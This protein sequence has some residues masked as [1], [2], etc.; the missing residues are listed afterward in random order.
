[1]RKTGK[2]RMVLLVF[3]AILL[4]VTGVQT[5]PA[6]ESQE[7]AVEQE[8]VVDSVS[9][10]KYDIEVL[11]SDETKGA[12]TGE[13]TYGPEEEVSIQAIPSEGYQFKQ[14]IDSNEEIVST[15]AQYTFVPT[16]SQS[17]YAVFEEV[18]KEEISD[19]TTAGIAEET[20]MGTHEE[21]DLISGEPESKA[22]AR[23]I[24]SEINTDKI[25]KTFQST[26]K[27][28]NIKNL[29]ASEH[30][31]GY[32]LFKWSKES[33]FTPSG[34]EVHYRTKKIG[35]SSWSG[36]TTKSFGAN[37]YAYKCPVKA[38]YVVE[39]HARAKGDTSWSQGVITTPA[40]GT[41]QA[42]KTVYVTRLDTN[43]HVGSSITIGLGE[44]I[45]VK[46][47]YEYP[48]RDYTKR[49]RLYPNHMLYDVANTSVV[50]VVK[51]DGT[52]YT[53]GI[54]DGLALIRGKKAGKTTIVFRAPNGRTQV[55][56]VTVSAK[57]A[58]PVS[59]VKYAENTVPTS[60]ADAKVYTFNDS[61]TGTDADGNSCRLQDVLATNENKK[62]VLKGTIQFSERYRVGSNTQIEATGAT[63]YSGSNGDGCLTNTV[64]GVNYNSVSN[65]IIRGG[66]WKKKSGYHEH[67]MM[68]LVHAN[69][70]R[71]ENITE[72]CAYTG[73]CVE[74]V[75]CQNV[76]VKNCNLQMKGEIA[77]KQDEPLQLDHANEKT[78]GSITNLKT[79]S[80]SNKDVLNNNPCKNIQIIGCTLQGE[81]GLCSGHCSSD[82]TPASKFHYNVVVQ[83][84]TIIGQKFEALAL[85]DVVGCDVSGN[86]IKSRSSLMD[87]TSD[88]MCVRIPEGEKAPSAMS[89]STIMI[90]NNIVFGGRSGIIVNT[91]SASDFG[92]V[93]ITGNSVYYKGKAQD[94]ITVS[95]WY[96]GKST[97]GCKSSK[98]S[99]NVT[100]KGW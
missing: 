1:M 9:T 44:S 100:K 90:R 45:R 73:H 70:I 18:I 26:R 58:N 53:G 78:A 79:S 13:G 46:P 91:Q 36:W 15:D 97:A 72:E 41:Y 89:T 80:L 12:V 77:G 34:W 20:H 69:N 7:S 67:A 42:M 85:Y 56:S 10:E 37:T 59:G 38:D 29:W 98:I 19:Q 5:I 47:D 8:E 40:G 83:N 14:W 50:S 87:Y 99:N 55:V 66:T 96:N 6:A 43:K 54:I 75:A 11:S 16:E 62:I 35:G 32:V 63:I 48:V 17:Y 27:A 74:L 81:R 49:P 84:N 2:F 23:E 28:C 71:I 93:V 25:Q 21:T 22:E 92:N 64:S 94:A 65:I 86:V 88:G 68:L 24:E 52:A 61:V 51:P 95:K 31:I 76:V 30:G 33:T 3:I 39:I 82:V 4:P 60:I 57:P